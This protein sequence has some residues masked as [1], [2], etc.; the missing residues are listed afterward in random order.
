MRL[1]GRLLRSVLV[2][3]LCLGLALGLSFGLSP[4]PA[5]AET[6]PEADRLLSFARHLSGLGRPELAETEYLRFLHLHPGHQEAAPALLELA[7]VQLS[8]NQPQR[9]I[10]TLA[11]LDQSQ[12]PRILVRGTALAARALTG[13]GREE[14]AQ[15]LLKGLADHTSLSAA[16]REEALFAL[17][18]FHLEDR[19][20]QAAG[21]AF[22]RIGVKGPLG[23]KAAF[24]AKEAPKGEKLDKSSP[25]LAGALSALLPGL[26]QAVRGQWIDS[27]WA[28]GLSLAP[29][30]VAYLALGAS[31]WATFGL[32][33]L[34]ALAF[35]G[36]NIYNAVN[37]THQANQA[38]EDRFIAGL[39]AQAGPLGSL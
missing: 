21:E 4:G 7:Q 31:A 30:I 8:L 6:G 9:A 23:I 14:E 3:Y 16:A 28:A 13:L 12:P 38:V 37:L 15:A 1:W 34:I 10:Q 35:Y 22:S 19:R 29:G 32:T 27:A 39:R 36:G 2:V 11:R 33:A 24:L 26:G 18:W 17:G 25:A 5:P 20:F